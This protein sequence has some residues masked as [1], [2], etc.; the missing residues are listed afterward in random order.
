M[1]T[2]KLKWL[3]FI[4]LILI[5]GGGLLAYCIQTAGNTIKIKDVRF[6]GSD[7]RIK[8]CAYTYRGSEQ[9]KSGAGHCRHTRLH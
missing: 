6:V 4:A 1:N 9:Q 7:G 8:Q 5:I 2:K 3:V